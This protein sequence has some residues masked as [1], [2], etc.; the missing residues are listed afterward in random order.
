MK[1]KVKK[2]YYRLFSVFLSLVMIVLSVPFS[3]TA[4]ESTENE[5]DL[6]A[7][8]G[9]PYGQDHTET[10]T[11]K[12]PEVL[13]AD[14]EA[15]RREQL[16][17]N[18]I[19][20]DQ[21]L[22]NNST[23]Q[24]VQGGEE[25]QPLADYP[26]VLSGG[27]GVYAIKHLC[28]NYF[29]K[30]EYPEWLAGYHMQQQY[31]SSSTIMNN[32]STGYLFKLTRNP[33][34]GSYI[35]R[36]MYNNALSF[37][38]TPKADGSGYEV[39]TKDIQL[40][41]SLVPLSDT[42][43]ISVSSNGNESGFKI[44][45][46]GTTNCIAINGTQTNLTA[47]TEIG[48]SIRWTFTQYTG[49]ERNS[50]VML[51]SSL[52]TVGQTTTLIPVIY[53]TEPGYNMPHLDMS[54][55]PEESYHISGPNEYG[56]FS[57]TPHDGPDWTF[58]IYVKNASSPSLTPVYASAQDFK[59]KLP[60]DEGTYFFENSE[61]SNMFM[62]IDDDVSNSTNG[63]IMELWD[64]DGEDDQKWE[65]DHL[66]DGYYKI[67]SVASGKALTGVT[68]ANDSVTQTD[69][70]KHYTQLWLISKNSNGTYSL[71]SYVY[72]LAAG[73]GTLTSDGRNVEGRAAQSDG[74]DEWKLHLCEQY[75]HI[76]RISRIL[77]DSQIDSLTPEE[78]ENIFNNA[79]A[80][81]LSEFNIAFYNSSIN[82]NASL[83]FDLNCSTPYPDTICNTD[84]GADSTC[85]TNH[86]KSAHKFLH[87]HKS[88]FYYTW[89]LVKHKLCY[90]D[91]EESPPEHGPVAG[92]STWKGKDSV[93][94]L[95][96]SYDEAATLQ[97]ELSHNLGVED[98]NCTPEQNCVM[99]HSLR[100][101]NQW[102]DKHSAMIR[103][104]LY[105]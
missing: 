55:I 7:S 91:L 11:Q 57:L 49:A 77:Y 73:A 105:N 36:L 44:R 34:T 21:P 2:A 10:P 104:Y 22:S 24:L 74:K 58:H 43:V 101:M 72:Y 13:A 94:S 40:D 25:L 26:Q 3:A 47:T 42:Y 28:G 85:N 5:T 96:E 35:I 83:S 68:E 33:Q 76:T 45:K 63:A 59:I 71:Y 52:P 23:A 69:Y 14:A 1:F 31:T 66:A 80:G 39:L 98:H 41:D 97:H 53:S 79:T 103:D 82:S 18:G 4:Q 62:E 9:T 6:I 29:I 30:A 70:T 86:H 32:F 84:C 17:Q 15:M 100:Y 65:L 16:I 50:A 51:Y 46:Y 61:F 37:A 102:C 99:K 38:I 56:R 67:T 48:D 12:S 20:P 60:I 54:Q 8:I 95:Y 87:M 89:R 92:L 93:V 90:Y 75:A 78:I 27:E 64:F 88:E 81:I 19:D